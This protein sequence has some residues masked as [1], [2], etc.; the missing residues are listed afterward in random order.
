MNTLNRQVA[1]LAAVAN[2]HRPLFAYIRLR[3]LHWLNPCAQSV[4]NL[5]A[6]AM[7]TGCE[8]RPPL[9]HRITRK[10]FSSRPRI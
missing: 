3:A 9:W 1:I 10:I 2:G 4:E 8:P 6:Y 7:M 5:R